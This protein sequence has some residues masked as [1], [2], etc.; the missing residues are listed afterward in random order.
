MTKKI[1]FMLIIFVSSFLIFNLV[2]FELLNQSMNKYFQ[3]LIFSTVLILSIFQPKLRTR[4][5]YVFFFLLFAAALLY[6]LGQLS[7]SNSLA[8]IA[9]GMVTIVSLTYL[10]KL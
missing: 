2:E 4:L 10:P 3:S 5:F 1:I 7:L 8:S 6:S 9:V